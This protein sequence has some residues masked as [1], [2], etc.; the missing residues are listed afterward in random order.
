MQFRAWVWHF[1]ERREPI[2]GGSGSAPASHVL[3]MPIPSTP[4]WI[5]ETF[6]LRHYQVLRWVT[7]ARRYCYNSAL[8]EQMN[9]K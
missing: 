7:A 5:C 2:P 4:L 3:D 1:E 9:Q 6:K 8:C